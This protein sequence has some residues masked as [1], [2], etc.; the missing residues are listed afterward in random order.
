MTKK[1]GKFTRILTLGV[2]VLALLM[3]GA[4]LAFGADKPKLVFCDFGWDSAQVHNR[5]AAFILEK[6]YGYKTEFV[7][8]ET[9]ML[10]KALIQAKSGAPNVNMETW[11]ENWQDLYDEGEAK[12]KDAGTNEGFVNLGSNFPNSVQGFYVPTYIIKGDEKRGIKAS[13]PDLKSVFDLPKYKELFKDPEDPKKGRFYSCI[14]GWSCSKVNHMKF[15]E[16]GLLDDYNIMEPGSGPALAASMEAAFMKGQPWLGYYWAPT[17][18]MGKLDMTMLEEP[19][20]D[21]KIWDTTKACAYPAVKCDILVHKSLLKTAPDVVEFLKNYETTMEINNKFLL[22][23]QET[24]GKPA[25]GAMWF[26]KE[27]EAL[28]TK[29]VTADAAAKVKAAMK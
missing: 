19:A 26:L 22:H 29:W 20:Y 23:M 27:Y 14:P 10:N 9:I 3:V 13:A 18:I 4:P 1:N 16:Y 12:G 15:K 21:Q 28:W 5:I 25:D 8:G 7:P 24:K 11:T 2:L 6:G 17:W